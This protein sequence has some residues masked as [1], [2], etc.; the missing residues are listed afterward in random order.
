MHIRGNFTNTTTALLANLELIMSDDMP[1]LNQAI[2]LYN[3]ENLDNASFVNH[4]GI[5]GVGRPSERPEGTAAQPVYRHEKPS[6]QYV[7]VDYSEYIEITDELAADADKRARL[8]QDGF[9]LKKA[10]VAFRDEQLCSTFNNGFASSGYNGFDG[11]PLFSTAHPM[12]GTGGG[13]QANRPTAGVDFSVTTLQT[14]LNAA[15]NFTDDQ[16]FKTG[17]TPLRIWHPVNLTQ[18]VE[19]VIGSPDRP[20][21]S[22]R[23]INSLFRK[24]LT[25][26]ELLNLTDTNAW[27]LMPQDNRM[28]KLFFIDRAKFDTIAEYI[29]LIKT[30]IVVSGERYDYGWSDWFPLYGSPGSS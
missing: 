22:D 19:E 28:H 23:S 26:I 9:N 13:T 25:N 5:T 16:G 17:A 11:V 6:K 8:K 27:G 15:K 2:A 10:H 24:N 12:Y 14:A 21:T 30:T 1:A 18:A 3:I 4:I 7:P 29:A 20:D